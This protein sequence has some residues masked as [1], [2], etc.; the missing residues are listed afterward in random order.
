MKRAGPDKLRYDHLQVLIGYGGEQAP[1]E[2]E[3]ANL[4]ADILVLLLDVKAPAELYLVLRDNELIA[5]PKDDNDIRPIGMGLV[6]LKLVSI[7]FLTHTFQKPVD[8]ANQLSESFNDHHFRNLQYGCTTRGAEKII[9]FT[10]QSLEVHADRDHFF[11]DADNAF[12]RVSRWKALEQ[13]K[14]HF[15]CIIPF[16]SKIYGEDSLGWY[17]GNSSEEARSV[18]GILGRR[19]SR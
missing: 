13:I 5:L 7:L 18:T 15:P 4:L 17:F 3:F 9:H 11:M 8:D 14:G 6:L 12:N 1:D 19:L 10:R 16:L 2:D